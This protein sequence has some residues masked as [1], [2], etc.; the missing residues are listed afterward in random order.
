MSPALEHFE[1]STQRNN[2]QF[3]PG[4]ATY[5]Y[6]D[7]SFKHETPPIADQRGILMLLYVH[8]ARSYLDGVHTIN[9]QNV[10]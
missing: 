4:T 6:S 1:R 2:V 7:I 9:N 5:I 8:V 3:L 10:Q